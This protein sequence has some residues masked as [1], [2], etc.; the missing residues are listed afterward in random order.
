[1]LIR[2]HAGGNVEMV[3]LLHREQGSD[4]NVRVVAGDERVAAVTRVVSHGETIEVLWDPLLRVCAHHI[5][6]VAWNPDRRNYRECSAH[7][8]PHAW[9]YQLSCY[10]HGRRL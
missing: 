7:T 9:K 6:A 1:M 8:L 5:F 2:D 4:V 3:E 10:T